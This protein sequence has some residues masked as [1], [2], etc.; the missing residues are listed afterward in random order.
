M[1][2]PASPRCSACGRGLDGEVET[3]PFCS[4]RCR[5]VDLGNWFLDR[6]R[7]SRGLKPEEDLDELQAALEADEEEGLAG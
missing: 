5:D 2:R 3:R 7:V 1:K 4:P 6:Y